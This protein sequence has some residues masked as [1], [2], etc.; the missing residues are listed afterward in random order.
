MECVFSMEEIF[1]IFE[2]IPLDTIV[3]ILAII[4]FIFYLKDKEHDFQIKIRE[5]L[6]NEADYGF[7]ELTNKTDDLLM[8]YKN[9]RKRKYVISIFQEMTKHC[10]FLVT[11]EKTIEQSAKFKR[12]YL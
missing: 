7:K 6:R 8:I 5:T 10:N 4:S 2:K 9:K 3:G 12:E 11:K 1:L